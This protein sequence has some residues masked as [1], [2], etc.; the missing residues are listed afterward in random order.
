VRAVGAEA[1]LWGSDIGC[2]EVRSRRFSNGN[3]AFY[4]LEVSRMLR[5][6]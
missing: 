3:V 1:D 5:L 2:W 6:G 4:R